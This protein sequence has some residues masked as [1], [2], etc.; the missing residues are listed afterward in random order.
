MTILTSAQRQYH[1]IAFSMPIVYT[2]DG[3]HDPNGMA[4]VL[5]PVSILLQWAKERWQ[6]DDRLLPRLHTR[7]Q[8]AQLVID[9]L[10]RLEMMLDR[11]RHGSTDDKNLLSELKNREEQPEYSEAEDRD[12]YAYPRQGAR[13]MAVR[14]NVQNQLDELRI[15]LT[16]LQDLD[17]PNSWHQPIK[18]D[19]AGVE[20]EALDPTTAPNPIR[21]ITLTPDQRRAW[22]QEW[23]TQA[24]MLDQAIEQWFTRCDADPKRR[25][26]A[27]ILSKESGIPEAWVKRL[28]LND[29]QAK[30]HGGKPY[31]RFNP[32]KPIPALRPLVLRCCQGETVKIKFENSLRSRRVGFHVQG[33]GMSTSE[34]A[35][36]CYADGAAIGKNDDSTCASG[37]TMTFYYTAK[38]EGVWPINDLADVRGGPDGTNAHGLFGALIVEAKGTQWCDP[39]TVEKA[40]NIPGNRLPGELTQAPWCSL[41][42]V[43]IIPAAENI[44]HPQ[45][46]AFIDFHC[47]T[48]P[49]S[50]REFTIFIHD[51]PEVHSGLHTIGE[52]S[53]MPL[54]YR[55]EP[56]PNRLPHRMRTHA[57]AT[58]LKPLP[59]K[60]KVDR[61]AVTWKLGD[62]LDEQFW[63]ARDSTGNY[64]ERVAGEEQH[65]SSWLFGDP[66]THVLRA[67]AGDPCRVR[68]IHAGVKETH[69]FH[70]HVHQWRAVASDT[71]QPSV[72]RS[73]HQGSQ[74]LDSI[75]IGPQ[76]AMTID[77][78]YGSG[79]RQHAMGD[80]IWHCHLYPHFH[81]G[82]WGLWRSFDRLVDGNRPYPDGSYCPPL[83]PL[84]GRKPIAPTAQ[85][86]GFP[87]FIDG[88]FPMKSPPPPV[89][90]RTPLNGRRIL[91]KMGPASRLEQ[92]AMPERCR[93]G[94]SSGA[95]FV[96]L[97]T[98]AEQWNQAAG[99]PKPRIISYDA[100][101]KTSE[102]QYNVDGW[103]DPLGHHYRLIKVEIREWSDSEN[104]YK[105]TYSETFPEDPDQNPSPFYPRANHGDIVEWRQ[106]NRLTSFPA[107]AFDL[108][109]APVECGLHVHLVKFDPL[110]ADGSATGWN[111]LSGASCREAVGADRSGE[112][113]TISRHRWVVDEEFGPCFFHDHLSANYRQKHGLFAALIAE[114]HASQWSRVD[115]QSLAAWSEPEAVIIP[116]ES[117]GLT[118]FREA[119]LAIAD[120]VTLLDK[121]DRALNPPSTLSGDDDP[122]GMAVNYRNA[123]LTFRGS[124]PSQWFSSS[125]RSRPNF[126]G[127]PGDPDTPVI[128]T[129]PGERL[130]IRLIQGSHEEQHG[131]ALHGMRWRRDWGNAKSPLVNQQTLG[132]SEAFTLDINPADASAYGVGDHLWHFCTADDLWLGCW[133]LVRSLVPI[134]EN[135]ARF[136]PLPDLKRSPAD[137]LKA[138]RDAQ[139][140][141]DL[142]PP[143]PANTRTFVVVAQR[144]E[145]LYSG[146]ALTDPWGLIYRTVNYDHQAEIEAALTQAIAQDFWEV[147]D[148][149][150]ETTDQP[151]V[152]RVRRGEW[153]RVILINDLL[154]VDEND[155]NQD[156]D[157]ALEFGVEPS[158]PRLP[159]EHLDDLA[160]PDRRTVS[161]RVSLHASLLRYD[162]NQCDGS[163]VGRNVDSTVAPW[164]RSSE[165]VGS[166]MA[167]G[168]I[169]GAVVHRPDHEGHRNWRE[170]WWYAD[171]ALAPESGYDGPG[172]VCYLYDLAD[173][174]N[175]R[176][177]GLIGALIVEP[178]DVTP[179]ATGSTSILDSIGRIW[180]MEGNGWSGVNAEICVNGDVIAYETAVFVQ[181]G[182]RFFVNGNP[183]FPMPDVNPKDDPEDSGQAGINYRSHPVHRGVV[184]KSPTPVFPLLEAMTGDKIWLRVIGAGDKP[185]QQTISVHG[186]AWP[187][188]SWV[189]QSDWTSTVTGLSP[190]RTETMVI[191][192]FHAGD[193]AVRSGA[194]RWA[195]EQGVWSSLRAKDWY[196]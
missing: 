168:E 186:C 139:Q 16:D 194:F 151:L 73:N 136:S 171:Q 30:N 37:K 51:E 2:L 155:P 173:I 8:R 190:C 18:Q 196:F 145:H 81:H 11:L 161:T 117:S 152:L 162:V 169:P 191:T 107:D 85:Q 56:M 20:P 166:H 179:F 77:P 150:V 133:G 163:Y 154:D 159:L 32:M 132:I 52:H 127:V 116:P 183:D 66:I 189:S 131:F 149:L 44:N 39:E 42:D 57:A 10:E 144:T 55:A 193:Y 45:H 170:Y 33:E 113:R 101:V 123:P 93:T 27:E 13:S 48:V 104:Q 156:S 46:Q 147:D 135:F 160:R 24:K 21:L 109:Q 59:L 87:W 90:D 64:L 7:R 146:T 106:H 88:V 102:I 91:L 167:M 26:N 68:L 137:A 22:R 192:L 181:N 35:G 122:G 120:F 79:S 105:S 5:K 6:D 103:H 34:G 111:Y 15:A 97:D 112:L 84:P 31:D 121:D 38:H 72:H 82:M 175:H 142:P 60:D 138:M 80:I 12:R 36:V 54:S 70:L 108:A 185:R 158:P 74:L 129:Y 14:L 78:L 141:T 28:L 99:L 43:D 86:P 89:G 1:V 83:N 67:Y 140:M 157:G 40:T 174:R 3:D 184:A 130:R 124:D 110:S 17:G 61:T 96:D 53:I 125:V 172:Q 119:C 94:E 65:H 128:H 95:I 100:E 165:H 187:A 9:G 76:S 25:F 118:P 49:R 143:D 114:P 98:K 4:Y 182:L 58:H 176:H 153:V 180:N 23:M 148:E 177:H 19:V 195:A 92:A 62:E 188:A 29:H 126:A 63:T 47:D 75:T 134:P 178:E 115:D 71:A 50:F 69:L 164:V 41:M